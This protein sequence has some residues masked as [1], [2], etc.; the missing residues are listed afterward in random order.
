M[1]V[2]KAMKKANPATLCAA[3]GPNGSRP[4]IGIPISK[5]RHVIQGIGYGLIPLH[6]D[7]CF[8][9]IS[10]TVTDV[11]AE[12]YR[13]RLATEEGLH[14][15]YSAE[16]NVCATVGLLRSGFLKGNALV[17]TVLCDTGLEY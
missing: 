14:V 11:D 12:D 13:K 17:A 4:L 5:P 15:G 16:A 7:S 8:I 9:D 10:L 1:G 2:A 3:V 6:W